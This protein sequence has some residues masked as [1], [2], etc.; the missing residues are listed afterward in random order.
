L[1]AMSIEAPLPNREIGSKTRPVLRPF[2]LVIA[3]GFA[4][5]VGWLFWPSDPVNSPHDL[6]RADERSRFYATAYPKMEA[7]LNLSLRGRLLWTWQQYQR[8]QATPNPAAYSFPARPIGFC[9]IHGMLNQ[10]MEISGT[11]YLIA[12]EITGVVELGS[13]NTL[14]VFDLSHC[15]TVR[16]GN[17]QICMKRI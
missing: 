1:R 4:A 8:R 3:F 12:V 10:C 15:V 11:Q 16:C 5:Y 14:M 2:V 13:T 17:G 7:P 6:S 9:S